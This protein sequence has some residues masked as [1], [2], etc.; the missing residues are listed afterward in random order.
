[1]RFLQLLYIKIKSRF[2]KEVVLV[3]DVAN[4]K[5]MKFK[6]GNVIEYQNIKSTDTVRGKRSEIKG[7]YY[8]DFE[9][10]NKEIL[11]GISEIYK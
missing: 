10:C 4:N 9:R 6:N 2:C 1:M 11:D 7:W 8:E 5:T 3:V